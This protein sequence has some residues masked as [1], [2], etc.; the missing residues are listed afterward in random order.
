MHATLTIKVKYDPAT[1]KSEKQIY[2]LLDW[3]AQHLAQE[4][5]LSDPD[6]EIIVDE[7]KHEVEISD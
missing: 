2:S 7:W 5:L 4:G 3:A 6:G 1:V